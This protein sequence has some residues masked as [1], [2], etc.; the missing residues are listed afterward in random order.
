LNAVEIE[1][2]ITRSAEE[3]VDAEAWNIGDTFIQRRSLKPYQKASQISEAF[4]FLYGDQRQNR[5][6]DTGIFNPPNE[7]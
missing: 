5:T 7:F 3:P 6:A 4:K 2:T 1:E